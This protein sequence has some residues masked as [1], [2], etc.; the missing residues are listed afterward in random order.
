LIGPT[1]KKKEYYDGLTTARFE[2]GASDYKV[3]VLMTLEN[4]T[5]MSKHSNFEE[6]YDN[7]QFM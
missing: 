6:E 5:K 3:A 1:A 4:F 7:G 2:L